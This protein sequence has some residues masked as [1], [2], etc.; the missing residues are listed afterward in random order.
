MD[1]IRFEPISYPMFILL[2]IVICMIIFLLFIEPRISRR[3]LLN[4]NEHGS[5]KFAD[6]KEIK[7]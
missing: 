6:L 7:N 4:K 5:S 2:I 1:N 3:K